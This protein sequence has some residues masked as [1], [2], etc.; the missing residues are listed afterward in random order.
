MDHEPRWIEV[1]YRRLAPDGSD[2]GTGRALLP[3][4][5]TSTDDLL[6]WASSRR[7]RDGG[8][9]DLELIATLG[10]RPGSP[11]GCGPAAGPWA[12]ARVLSGPGGGYVAGYVGPGSDPGNVDLV[13]DPDAAIRFPDRAAAGDWLRPL[14]VDAAHYRPVEVESPAA[15]GAEAVPAPP[16]VHPGLYVHAATRSYYVVLGVGTC[17]T[18]GPREG[19]ERSVVYYSLGRRE[20]KYRE[21]SEFLTPGR[22]VRLDGPG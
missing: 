18:N 8:P 17:S 1:E 22:F 14:G 2:R 19:A 11:H 16:D 4:G 13:H 9:A 3:A 7:G 15:G 21:A 20:L 6:S 12:V 5:L 10:G